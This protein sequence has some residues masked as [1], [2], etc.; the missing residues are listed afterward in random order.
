MARKVGDLLQSLASQ[1]VCYKVMVHAVSVAPT[2]R[3]QLGMHDADGGQRC[4]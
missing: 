2:G 1:H 4:L 3:A